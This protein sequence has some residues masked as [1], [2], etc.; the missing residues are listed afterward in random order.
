MWGKIFILLF[1]HG[2]LCFHFALK[3]VLKDLAM[4]CTHRVKRKRTNR[5]NEWEV[6]EEPWLLL[7]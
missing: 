5:G 4:E 6:T 3:S 1:E 7:C 2:L